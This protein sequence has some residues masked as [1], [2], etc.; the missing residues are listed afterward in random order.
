M[1]WHDDPIGFSL[2]F[3]ESKEY[4]RLK[5]EALEEKTQEYK[6]DIAVGVGGAVAA[7]LLATVTTGGVGALAY[8]GIVGARKI[9]TLFKD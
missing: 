9:Y 7:G 5:G 3:E 4:S 6:T 1:A 8:L 2:E